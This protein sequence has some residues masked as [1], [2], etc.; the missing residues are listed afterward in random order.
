[1]TGRHA[2]LIAISVGLAL[3]ATGAVAQPGALSDLRTRAEQGNAEAQFML[4]SMYADGTVLDQDAVA[5]AQW[6]LRSAEQG[7]AR[8]FLPLGRA[9]LNGQGVAQDY[10]SAHLWFNI[11]AARLSG[12]DRAVAVAERDRVQAQ[13]V[14]NQL[15]EAQRLARQWAPT[16]DRSERV[17]AQPDTPPVQTPAAGLVRRADPVP[18]R[19]VSRPQSCFSLRAR[20]QNDASMRHGSAG[21][22]LG[23]LGCG[24]G[25]GF[26]G[27]AVCTG[28][29]ALS[30]P[31]PRAIDSGLDESCYRDGYRSRARKKNVLSTLG[32]SLVGTAAWLVIFF[33]G[34]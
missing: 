25:V 11:A 33:V 22:F 9:Y 3:W 29:S 24:A 30:S 15:Q 6:F 1:M 27:A 31:Q 18:L 19:Q 5:A 26:I 28:G 4:G 21:W 10:V 16:G 23:G 34:N 32:G 17:A 2:R 14:G 20:G 8:S 13:M 7:Y 12:E